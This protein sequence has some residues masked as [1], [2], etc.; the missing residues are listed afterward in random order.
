MT[1]AEVERHC[2]MP[3]IQN[4]VEKKVNDSRRSRK[5]LRDARDT[6]HRRTE[7]VDVEISANPHAHAHEFEYGTRQHVS[8]LFCK[9]VQKY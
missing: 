9:N 2:V 6:K 7:R 5:T 1:R 3:E 4:T 8:L